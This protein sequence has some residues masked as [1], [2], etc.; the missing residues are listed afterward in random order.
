MIKEAFEYLLTPTTP[1]ARR[2]GFLYSSI[3]LKHRYERCK[4]KW[5]PHLKNCQDL[6]LDN[7][8]NL[9]KKD[10]VIILGSAHLHE[11]PFH[12]LIANFKKVTL[13]D[14]IHPLKHHILAKRHKNLELITHD[15]SG[16]LSE[17]EDIETYEDLLKLAHQLHDKELFKFDADLIVSGNMLS[18]LALMP[19]EQIE[20]E[21]SRELTLEEKDALCTSFAENHLKNITKCTGHKLVYSDRHITYRSPKN[22]VIYEGNYPVDFTGFTFIKEWMWELAP[23][24]EASKDYAIEMKVE[25]YKKD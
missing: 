9:P 3:S 11:I 1:L 19:I 5:L 7:V 8:A 4:I 12:L 10:H 25:A 23:Q 2:Y 21:L 15:L 16:A 14:I 6:F 17:L 24:G 22:E 20:K 18:Q 13:V